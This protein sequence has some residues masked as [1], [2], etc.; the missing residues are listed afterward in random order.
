[1][2]DLVNVCMRLCVFPCAAGS[3]GGPV[4]AQ[5]DVLSPL[6]WDVGLDYTYCTQAPLDPQI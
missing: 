4:L 5:G 3:P 2:P 1:M 6:P